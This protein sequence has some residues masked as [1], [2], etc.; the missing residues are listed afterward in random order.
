TLSHRWVLSTGLVPHAFEV[1]DKAA[2]NFGV[3]PR[4]PFW[5]KPLVEF[6]LALPGEKKLHNGFGRHVLRRAMEGVLPPMVQWRRDK[7]DF[8]ANLV[9]GMLRNHRDLLDTVLV[10]D[11]ERIAPYVNLPQ[12]NAA[13]ARLLD[14]PDEA[15][16][17]DVQ[18]VWRSI[19]LSLWLRQTQL[20]GNP[21]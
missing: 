21:A 18:Y 15:A 6:C 13:Y 7:I 20:A 19:S 12:V 17:L 11:G 3:E 1:L 8:T 9:K 2:A 5:D 14:K 4:Y 16:P 10:S